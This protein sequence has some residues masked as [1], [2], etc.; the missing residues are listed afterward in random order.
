M[1]AAQYA[2]MAAAMSPKADAT[3]WSMTDFSGAEAW[4]GADDGSG[5]MAEANMTAAYA[6]F[7][8]MSARQAEMNAAKTANH[9]VLMYKHVKE[10]EA[11]VQWSEAKLKELEDWKKKTLEDMRK[12]R[13]EHKR[14]RKMIGTGEADNEETGIKKAVSMPVSVHDCLEPMSGPPGL[15][16]PHTSKSM[17]FTPVAS[18]EALKITPSIAYDPKESEV[19]RVVSAGDVEGKNEGVTVTEQVVDGA[20]CQRAEWHIGHL[21]V[22]LRGCMGRALVSPPFAA[23][24]ME[25]LRLMIYPDQKE[26]TTGPRSRRQKELYNKKVSDGPLDGCLKLK[27]PECPHTLVYYLT[28]GIAE[29]N[30]V[31]PCTQNFAD[32]TVSMAAD[33]GDMDWLQQ[34]D[35]DGGLTV[36][37]DI[38]AP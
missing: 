13:D 27:V 17:H 8:E 21:S 11:K 20:Q 35:G 30:R 12:L 37:V 29:R 32:S 2:Q 6:A 24:G 34:V 16:L 3:D 22:K 9:V 31:G 28:V 15:D 18:D 1:D 4:T 38:K 36:S 26:P 23:W 19:R 14:L 7:A 33:F 5:T 10:L 25:D